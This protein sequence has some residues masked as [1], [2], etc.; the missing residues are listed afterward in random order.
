T[1]FD[2]IKNL[3]QLFINNNQL[4]EL[5][6]QTLLSPGVSL[7]TLDVSHN[8]FP[9][10]DIGQILLNLPLLKQFHLVSCHLNDTSIYT[11]LKL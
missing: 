2:Q 5:Y 6:P 8:Q 4:K 1:A 3:K 10:L 9:Y 11:L 7:Q